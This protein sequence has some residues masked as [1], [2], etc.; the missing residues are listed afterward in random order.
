MFDELEDMQVGDEFFVHTL[1]DTYAYRVYDTEVLL[2]Q[3][4]EQ[5]CKIVSHDDLCTLM[6]CT[7]YGI[8][9]HRLLVHGRR[10]PYVPATRESTTPLPLGH[11]GRRQR[12]LVLVM[13][14]L[15]GLIL[16]AGIVRIAR[17]ARTRL[18][19]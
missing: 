5:H 6:T 2:P 14:G 12:P 7:P 13:A 8:N 18:G 17:R 9:T 3:D 4:A 19:R 1:C 10:V 16:V 11:L 15:L